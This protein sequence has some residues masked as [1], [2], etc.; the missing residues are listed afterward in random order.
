MPGSDVGSRGGCQ[1]GV[2]HREAACD[3]VDGGPDAVQHR[4]QLVRPDL[5]EAAGS[6]QR[7]SV[8]D[9]IT[10][11][12][13]RTAA[14]RG[15]AGTRTV[16]GQGL[17]PASGRETS[18]GISFRSGNDQPDGADVFGL[19]SKVSVSLVPGAGCEVGGEL[20]HAASYRRGVGEHP[21]GLRGADVGVEERLGRA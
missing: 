5:G 4:R 10:R 14:L 20:V 18:S 19:V 1:R 8:L 3:D 9:H 7:Q 21:S 13:F 17:E 12:E 16:A 6:G 11:P 2:H 15:S